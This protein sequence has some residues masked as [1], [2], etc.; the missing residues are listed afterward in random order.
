M[1]VI[2][3]YQHLFKSSIKDLKQIR[4]IVQGLSNTSVQK[5]LSKSIEELGLVVVVPFSRFFAKKT[6]T[7]KYKHSQLLLFVGIYMGGLIQ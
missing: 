3:R 6:M 1:R 5:H 7:N 4:V 2:N